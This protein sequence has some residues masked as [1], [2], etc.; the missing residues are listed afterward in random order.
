MMKII[1]TS[2]HRPDK[3]Q[4]HTEPS[5]VSTAA[6][7]NIEEMVRKELGRRETMLDRKFQL[8]EMVSRQ[9]CM[10]PHERLH[11]FDKACIAVEDYLGLYI[12][13]VK[14]NPR[15]WMS[16]IAFI[17][18]GE[19]ACVFAKGKPEEA[20][21]MTVEEYQAINPGPPSV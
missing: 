17:I 16:R 8:G 15:Y 11:H 6:L 5:K 10:N 18:L 14:P 1:T 7:H 9:R 19:E 4:W 3:A 13:G 2:P 12:C 20:D 21:Q